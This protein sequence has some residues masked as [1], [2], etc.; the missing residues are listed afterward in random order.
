MDLTRRTVLLAGFAAAS[1]AVDTAATEGA[2]AAP[3]RALPLPPLDGELRFD[4]ASRIAAADD[5]GHIVHRTPKGVLLPGSD[6]DVATTIRW[7]GGLGRKIVP[8]GQS[9]SVYGRAQVRAGIVI[10]MTQ[11]RTVYDVQ[12]DRVVV[13]AGATWSE[14]LAATL[15]Q[16]FTPP[17]L[18][19]Y[20]ALSIGGTLVVGGI[21]GTTSQYGMQSDN[22]LELEVVTGTGEKVT[23]APDSNADLFDAVR[24]GLGQVAIITRATLKLIPAP[25]RVRRY[26]LTYPDL[27]T[28]L[29]DERLLAADKRFD[30][31]QGA[32]LPTPTG[33]KYRL[34]AVAQF[35]GNNPP[36]D[37]ILL[38]GLSDDRPAAQV[39]TLPYFDDLNRL[40]VLE[41]LLRANGQWFSPH[42]WLTTFV[43][44][45][46][47]ESVVSDE[48]ARLTPA[49]LGPFG[50][51]VLSAFPSQA[52]TSPLLRLPADKLV[53]AFNLVRIPTT[54]DTTEVN[55][56]VM[57]N[58]AIYERV[59]AAGGT[60]YPVSAFPMSRDDWRQHF[61]AVWG[62]LRDAKQHFDPRHVL[63]P[64]YEVF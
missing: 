8:Q 56:L 38:A 28:L 32:V 33:W 19:D 13:D 36:D 7:A 27:R 46:E 26:V 31:A 42:P 21:G 24:A 14:V 50:Q 5:F 20:L 60:L 61:G 39:S 57:A 6:Q 35:A 29:T 22:V 62:R 17:V 25:E 2:F 34:D 40:A 43:G 53:Y 10:D 59:R 3:S 45:G 47:V 63:T 23:C 55:R 48:L 15:P 52:V 58:R 64:G 41:L 12:H 51:V 37:N 18:T 44:D 49:D 11:L 16:G 9:H 1:V 30:A 4:K 54:N